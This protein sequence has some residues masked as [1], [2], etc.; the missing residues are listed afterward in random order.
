MERK[1]GAYEWAHIILKIFKLI[2]HLMPTTY[3]REA[4]ESCMV[5]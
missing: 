4:S 2:F 1:H 5:L 3:Q